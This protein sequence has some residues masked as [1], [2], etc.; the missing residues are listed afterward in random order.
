[1]KKI[2]EYIGGKLPN[3]YKQFLS[4]HTERFQND[5]VALYLPDEIIER[6]EIYETKIY[7]PGY[8]NIGDDSG[9]FAFLL[10]LGENDPSVYVVGHGSMD[11][12]F[13]EFVFESFSEWIK[14]GCEY[15]G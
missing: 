11:P 7:A 8:I 13:M 10:K 5:L 4:N 15:E 3:S 14:S 6:N 2:E 1:M 9:G 12:N